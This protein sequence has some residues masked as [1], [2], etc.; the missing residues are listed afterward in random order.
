MSES[1]TSD[2]SDNTEFS[3]VPEQH[4][5]AEQDALPA[6]VEPQGV[7]SGSGRDPEANRSNA[8]GSNAGGSNAGGSNGGGSNGVGSD[9]VIGASEPGE[10]SSTVKDPSD[11]VTGDEPMTGAQRS[12]LETLAREAGEQLP[13]D[14]TKAQASEHIDRLQ[15]ATGRGQGESA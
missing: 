5:Q 15:A 2:R 9:D 11:W 7:N 1:A 6:L 3:A 8:G 14:L 4:G 12:Y 13:A 10:A